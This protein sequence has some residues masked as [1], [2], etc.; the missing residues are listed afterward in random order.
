M[1]GQ[2][3]ASPAASG[4][5]SGTFNP[6]TSYTAL[7]L[8]LLV[9]TSNYIDRQILAGLIEPIKDDLGISDTM[10]GF[11]TG[12]VFALF[13]SVLG[14]PMAA[15]ADRGNR[16][17]LIVWS[18]SIWSA[19]TALCGLA[20]NTLQLALARIGVGIGEAGSSPP[21]HSIIS[22]L[23][24]PD[25]R[26]FAMAIFSMGVN[27]GILFGFIFAGMIY[28]AFD[29]NWRPAFFVV[30]LPG[31]LLAVIVRFALKEPKRGL[32]EAMQ[33]STADQKPLAE[34]LK[35]TVHYIVS[36][37]A[38]WQL[39]VGCTAVVTYGY[40]FVT[41]GTSFFI[42][43]HGYSVK[44]ATTLM[45]LLIGVGG[46]IG[47]LLC[48]YIANR[49]AIK[50]PAYLA[51]WVAAVTVVTLP[52]GVGTFLVSS[53]TLAAVLFGI[54]AFAGAAYLGPSFAMAQNLVP[55][56]MRSLVAG[57]FLFVINFI[58]Y[59]LGPM[60][61]GAISDA[62][63]EIYGNDSLRYALLTVAPINII[64][65]IFYYLAGKNLEEGYARA[66]ADS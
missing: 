30:G 34:G 52:F 27:L 35:E 54:S 47:T 8:L 16:R 60:G 25:K 59:F 4:N 14:I 43:S 40:I 61:A 38:L 21:S 5:G 10:V 15:W 56:R 33:A 13:Y 7:F 46:G 6:T 39:F 1:S 32:S 23:F 12:G 55:V 51:W 65:V 42:R 24:P 58:G 31:L 36:Q 18:L 64:T 62:Y 22:D 26:P 37:R 63:R 50:K 28:E 48:G 20:Q 11:L 2:G 45:G 17:N 57:V 44:E 41:W 53:P 66:Q 3:E 19:M 49:L 29:Y 9:Y